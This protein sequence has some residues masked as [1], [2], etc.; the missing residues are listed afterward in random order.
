MTLSNYCFL[1]L[2]PCQ[3]NPPE[4]FRMRT[5]IKIDG[6]RIDPNP[7][8]V[9]VPWDKKADGPFLNVRRA[10][11][12]VFD[13]KPGS[14]SATEWK[15]KAKEAYDDWFADHQSAY[16][17]YRASYLLAA[18]KHLDPAS[19]REKE[20]LRVSSL[21][22]LGWSYLRKPPNSYE[23]VRRAYIDNANDNNFHKFGDLQQRLLSRDSN[24]R[25]VIRAIC[26]EYRWRKP[27]PS[28]ERMMFEGIERIRATARWRPNDELAYAIVLW[29]Y[30]RKHRKLEKYDESLLVLN[31]LQQE[32]SGWVEKSVIEQWIDIVKRAKQSGTFDSGKYIDDL[33][34]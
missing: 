34:P 12:R 15:V 3:A 30:G 17:L 5:D 31:K 23:F 16:K 9:A 26:S 20:F 21:L 33:H 32:D 4:P 13:K 18:V 7:K 24:D 10:V 27:L 14:I 22:N 8:W 19:A 11:D 6:L 29:S 28:F 25:A 1:L 2:L